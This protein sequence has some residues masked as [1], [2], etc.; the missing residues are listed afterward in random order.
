MSILLVNFSLCE[1]VMFKKFIMM[2]VIQ[3]C[4]FDFI[5]LHTLY[6]NTQTYSLA[7][8]NP[9]QMWTVMGQNLVFAFQSLSKCA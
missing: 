7:L 6:A 4:H 9:F 2:M 8:I 3:P 5:A 1:H